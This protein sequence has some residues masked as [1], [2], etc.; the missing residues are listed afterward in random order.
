M[1]AKTETIGG[2]VE[3]ENFSK[4]PD[5]LPGHVA[6]AVTCVATDESLTADQGVA[7]QIPPGPILLCRLIMK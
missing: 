4:N 7:N 6:Q 3:N 2:G 1:T 5:N